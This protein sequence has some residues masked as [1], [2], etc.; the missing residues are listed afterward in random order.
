MLDDG[1]TYRKKYMVMKRKLR[2]L[3]FEQEAF[4]DELKTSQR[5]LLN[6]ARDRT[7]LLDRLVDYEDKRVTSADTDTSVDSENTESSD[8][9]DEHLNTP[10]RKKPKLSVYSSVPNRGSSSKLSNSVECNS[11]QKRSG[12]SKRDPSSKPGVSVKRSNTSTPKVSLFLDSTSED[13]RTAKGDDSSSR[14]SIIPLP[15]KVRT[16]THKFA[17]SDP[18]RC[19]SASSIGVGPPIYSPQV[20]VKKRLEYSRLHREASVASHILPD[21]IFADDTSDQGDDDNSTLFTT[22]SSVNNV[23]I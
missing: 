17:I 13:G 9:D 4:M 23:F 5:K 6:V 16:Q 10:S 12:A 15:G 21:N 1:D 20:D 22:S 7:F 8:D 19:S 11:Y 3:V 18:I 14:S 2:L